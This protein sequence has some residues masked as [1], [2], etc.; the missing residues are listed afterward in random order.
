MIT[1]AV[2]REGVD[3]ALAEDAPWGDITAAAAIP[4]QTRATAFLVAREEGVLAG[5]VVFREAFVRTDERVEVT[6]LL[7]DGEAFAAGAKLA[8]VTG[9]A[10][11]ILTAERVALNFVQRMSG[12]AMLTSR[13]V[14]AT[15]G[16]RA[17]I[18]DTRKTTPGLRA[19][20]KYAVVCG[21]GHNHRFG[22]SDAILIKDN[23][24]ALLQTE[25]GLN[26]TDALI[27]LRETLGHTVH[28]EVEVDR[29]NQIE[30]VLAAGV[31]TIMLDNFTV[32]QLYA[33]VARVG[34]R[35]LVEA[36]GG[37]TLKTVG[38]IAKT[39]V[40]L[41]SVGALTHGVRSLDMG[42]DVAFE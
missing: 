19:F 28:I 25:L 32:P 23:H 17:Q 33:G 10:R 29:E 3:R 34:G 15:E 1:T 20:E 24:L 37:I 18:V 35:A 42:L 40:D 27:R 11:P 2:L 41:I 14:A 21:G 38:K 5:S 13:Y 16:T 12:I 6:T 36:S 31:D 9:P 4:E 8:K 22:L 30:A 26:V 7:G 39:G